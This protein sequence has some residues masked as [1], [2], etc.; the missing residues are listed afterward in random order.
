VAQQMMVDAV[1]TRAVWS[2]SFVEQCARVRDEVA[3]ALRV[4]APLP[5]GAYYFFFPADRYLRGRAYDTVIEELL[6]AGVS[7]APGADFGTD[8][9][10]WIR[11]CFAGESPQRVLEGVRRL[12]RVLAG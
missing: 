1:R 9:G 7:V 3:A 11:I 2:R 6:D 12:N 4:A 10:G 8:F 5:D